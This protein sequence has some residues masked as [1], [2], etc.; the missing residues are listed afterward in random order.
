[1]LLRES[2]NLLEKPILMKERQ[3]LLP[4]AE[5]QTGCLQWRRGKGDK[6]PSDEHTDPI[7]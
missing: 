3:Q 7:L 2:N 4:R 6:L 1:M 5:G